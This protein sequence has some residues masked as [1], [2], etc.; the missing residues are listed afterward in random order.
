MSWRKSLN[1]RRS[2]SL[3]LEEIE[4]PFSAVE[5]CLALAQ[6][7]AVAHWVWVGAGP[8]GWPPSATG[9]A[10]QASDRGGRADR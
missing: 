6:R 5:E 10:G 4:F 9:T 2:W 8:R 1:L 3:G 7:W